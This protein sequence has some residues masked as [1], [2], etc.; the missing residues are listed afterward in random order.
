MSAR[1]EIVPFSEW[2]AWGKPYHFP[3]ICPTRAALISKIVDGEVLKEPNSIVV[4]YPITRRDIEPITMKWGELF[5]LCRVK[6][7]TRTRT[8][9]FGEGGEK[10]KT[11]FLLGALR[12]LPKRTM[13]TIYADHGYPLEVLFVYGGEE[14]VYRAPPVIKMD[15]EED[16]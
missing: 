12:Y 3:L 9:S 13:L 16:E 6:E 11:P 5:K 2:H 8:F 10:Y 1:H 15:D 7:Y 4:N 14:W